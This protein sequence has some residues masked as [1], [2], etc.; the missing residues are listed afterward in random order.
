MLRSVAVEPAKDNP[1]PR[2]CR[3]GESWSEVEWAEL[4]SDGRYFA[5]SEGWMEIRMCV[6]GARL[7]VPEPRTASPAP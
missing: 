3:C 6:C 2:R 7:I 1:W 4:P 5:G